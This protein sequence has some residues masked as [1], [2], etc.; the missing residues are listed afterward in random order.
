MY[1]ISIYYLLPETLQ[2]FSEVKKFQISQFWNGTIVIA[3]I[4]KTQPGRVK[5]SK[6]PQQNLVE[7][8]LNFKNEEDFKRRQRVISHKRGK[9]VK[10]RILEIK[11]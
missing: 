3:L 6:E 10:R 8:E 11:D 7:K 9:D 1:C 2:K 5:R 4:V